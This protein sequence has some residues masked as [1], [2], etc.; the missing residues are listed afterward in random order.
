M[1][2]RSGRMLSATSRMVSTT[3]PR[4]G[5]TCSGVEFD[6]PG[7]LPTAPPGLRRCRTIPALASTQR[8]SGIAR[9]E[10]IDRP[11]QRSHTENIAA[12]AARLRWQ[13]N[14]RACRRQ[15]FRSPR[16]TPLRLAT[17]EMFASG[18]RLSVMIRAFWSAV[19]FCRR[20]PSRRV[21]LRRWMIALAFSR[22]GSSSAPRKA[23]IRKDHR[24]RD[25]HPP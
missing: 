4:R 21:V 18:S 20:R 9:H 19:Q 2:M 15:T 7:R 14:S 5:S 3:G 23:M 17:S 13:G 11:N 1:T 10:A 8:K 25:L 12:Q 22:I 16:L 24:D 6:Q